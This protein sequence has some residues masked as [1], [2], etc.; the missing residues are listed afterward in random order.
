[1]LLGTNTGIG[2]L[3]PGN[4]SNKLGCP[5]QVPRQLIILTTT[6]NT[7]EEVEPSP[8]DGLCIPMIVVS[9]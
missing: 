8:L 1:M 5:V 9:L 2:H 4:T 6:R 3:P 7:S